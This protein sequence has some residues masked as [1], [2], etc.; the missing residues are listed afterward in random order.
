MAVVSGIGVQLPRALQN[1]VLNRDTGIAMQSQG[2]H[3]G[4]T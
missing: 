3:E 1:F 4:S 2:Q